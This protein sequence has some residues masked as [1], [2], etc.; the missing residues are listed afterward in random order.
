MPISRARRGTSTLGVAAC[1]GLCA[2]LLLLAPLTVD[3]LDLGGTR[4]EAT[5]RRLGVDPLR[6]YAIALLETGRP[7]GS[8]AIA[9]WPWSLRTGKGVRFYAT[10]AAAQAA[11]R[12]TRGTTH[13]VGVGLLAVDLGQYRQRV[14]DPATLLDPGTNLLVGA[15]I[16]AD[17]LAS[18][19]ND[20]ALGIGRFYRSDDPA[21]ARRFGARILALVAALRHPG[22]GTAEGDPLAGWQTNAVLDLVAV[23]ESRGNYNALYRAADQQAVTLADLTVDGVRALQAQLIHARG[24][25]AIGRHQFLAATLERLAARAGLQG[26][27]RFTPALQDRLAGQ[28]AHEAGLAAWLQGTLPD[29]RFAANL[30]RVWAG[31]PRDGSDQS[32]YAGINGNQATIAWQTVVSRLRAIRGG[33]RF[34]K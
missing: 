19:P 32:A 34:A 17:T 18:A 4:W 28:L 27:E 3:A 11:L 16:L 14:G 26:S 2:V 25:S 24:G 7:V 1:R 15:E 10:R 6:L 30:A 31:L 21:A 13:D 20:P 5:A 33:Q 12:S 22:A 9:P 23:P 8:E 29:E